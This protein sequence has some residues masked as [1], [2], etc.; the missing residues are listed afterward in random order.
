MNKFIGFLLCCL[1]LGVNWACDDDEEV[2]NDDQVTVSLGS[3]EFKTLENITPLRIPV[4]LS[5]AAPQ[6]VSVTGYIKSENN[7]KEGVDYTFVSKQLVIPQGKS[8]GF[9]EVEIKDYPEYMPDRTFEFEIVGVEGAK[10]SELDVCQVIIMS[11]EGLPVLGFAN[12]LATIGEEMQQLEIEVKTDRIWEEA[13]PFRV[14]ILPDKSNAVYG[15]HYRLDTAQVYAIAAGDTSIVIPVEIIDNIEINDAHS[16]EIEIYDNR[17]S[18]LSE[19]YRNMKVTILDDE[20][21]VYVCFDKTSFGAVESEG[22]V[23]IPVRL[24][25]A[26]RV[27]VKVVLEARGGTAVEGV[28]YEFPQKELTFAVG[29]KLD[30]VRIDFI[31]ND[32]NDLDRNLQIGFASVEGAMLASSD[33]LAHV[34]IMNDDFNFQQLYEDLMGQWT[35]TTTEKTFTVQI[36]GGDTPAEEDANYLKRL[37]IKVEG[38]GNSGFP[39]SIAIDYDVETGKMTVPMRQAVMVDISPSHWASQPYGHHADN[40]MFLYGGGAYLETEK[41]ELEWNKAYTEC[42]WNIGGNAIRG[43]LCPTGTIDYGAW[44]VYDFIMTNVVMTRND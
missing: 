35:L 4:A 25:G 40:V 22:P 29:N 31:D 27:P 24:K 28:D 32:V 23:W 2:K 8:S 5:A 16:F 30:S 42:S 26:P 18:V 44:N 13:V 19:V 9:F 17:N 20:E 11:N 34:S 3:K 41:V 15:E 7:A 38:L 12:T 39:A 21:P 43:A 33:T 1:F 14:K 10:L 6:P 36:S 37:I